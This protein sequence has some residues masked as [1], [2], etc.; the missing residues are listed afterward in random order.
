MLLKTNYNKLIFI[1]H[2]E[3]DE[4]NE[5]AF[6]YEKAT[7]TDFSHFE[8]LRLKH[9]EKSKVLLKVLSRLK[10]SPNDFAERFI[11]INLYNQEAKDN[12]HNI[13]KDFIEV[14]QQT[15]FL[16]PD[17]TYHEFLN[18]TITAADEKLDR[19]YPIGTSFK[20]L[21]FSENFKSSFSQKIIDFFNV[22]TKHNYVEINID[23][24]DVIKIDGVFGYVVRIYLTN[25]ILEFNWTN[26]SNT[27][28]GAGLRIY[29]ASKILSNINLSYD[30]FI[31]NKF[32]YTYSKSDLQKITHVFGITISK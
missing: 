15:F 6:D 23:T 32:V 25:I 1:S 19:Y 18:S 11:N 27:K 7:K 24:R 9:D 20:L 22:K 4:L 5:E 12:T 26:F 13:I 10:L 29:N 17:D 8:W 30:E 28:K 31:S 2:K 14:T 21:N 3:Y 16:Q